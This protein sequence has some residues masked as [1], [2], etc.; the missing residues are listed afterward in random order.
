MTPTPL[1][2]GIVVLHPLFRMPSPPLLVVIFVSLLPPSNKI[3]K[4]FRVFLSPFLAL[5][6]A[7]FA[8]I[9][10]GYI[11]PFSQAAC[12]TKHDNHYILF[13]KKRKNLYEKIG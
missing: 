4:A 6:V 1:L 12:L 3:L 10:M 5:L 9:S 11:A 8:T 13:E 7:A 2:A